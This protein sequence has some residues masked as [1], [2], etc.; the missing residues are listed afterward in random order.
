[1]ISI[2]IPAYNEKENIIPLYKAIVKNMSHVKEDYEMI[3]VDDG[4]TDNTLHTIKNITSKNIIAIPLPKNYGQSYALQKG[5]EAAKGSIIITMDADL[6]NDP[7]DIPLMLKELQDFDAVIGYRK[8]RNDSLMIKKVPSKIFNLLIRLMFNLKIH[9][10]SCTF[11]AIKKE[12]ALSLNLKPGYHRMIPI[13]LHKKGFMIKEQE[14]S[15][16]PRK[17]GTPKYNSPKRFIQGLKNLFEIWL[18]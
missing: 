13:L 14:I 8:D 5:I 3:I 18:T 1:M 15:H 6:Q 10:C 2:I 9:D 17:K 12:A 4:S 7:K 16:N 11:K